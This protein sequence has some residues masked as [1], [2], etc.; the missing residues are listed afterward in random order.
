MSGVCYVITVTSSS[1][2][3]LTKP[4]IGSSVDRIFR[5]FF[6]TLEEKIEGQLE[7]GFILTNLYEDTNGEGKLH[8]YNIPSFWAT[9]AVKP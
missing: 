3:I 2:T 7:A 6:H 4:R 1:L 5:Q 9:C 8:E